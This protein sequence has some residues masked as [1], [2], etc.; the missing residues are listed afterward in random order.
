[1]HSV[2]DWG[3]TYHPGGHEIEK[4]AV[5]VPTYTTLSFLLLSAVAVVALHVRVWRAIH[6]VGMFIWHLIVAGAF[7]LVAIWFAI[8]ITGV[9]I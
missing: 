1:M 2:P 9:F 3:T 7:F 4:W 6:L 8:N 5:D